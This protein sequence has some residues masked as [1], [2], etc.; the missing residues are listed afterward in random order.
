L[1]LLSWRFYFIKIKDKRKKIKV[2][3]PKW[4]I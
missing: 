2:R 4:E 1:Y 3:D